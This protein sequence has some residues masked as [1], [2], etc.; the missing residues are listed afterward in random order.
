MKESRSYDDVQDV[1][2]EMQ[3]LLG[4]KLINNGLLTEVMW[5][6]GAKKTTLLTSRNK[7]W[8]KIEV[9]QDMV[10]E[11]I[12]MIISW[13][14]KSYSRLGKVIS[15]SSVTRRKDVFCTVKNRTGITIAKDHK[16]LRSHKFLF[17]EAVSAISYAAK[18]PKWKVRS[19]L[20][21]T[22]TKNGHMTLR[23]SNKF[24]ITV[25]IESN[26]FLF[27]PGNTHIPEK[28]NVLV[29]CTKNNNHKIYRRLRKALK[30]NAVKR[31][32][33][34]K[35]LEKKQDIYFSFAA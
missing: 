33:R 18:I 32:Y 1:F 22:V 14:K 16:Q 31:R 25:C 21:S 34:A 12:I 15:L 10:T 9:F 7:T 26:D 4:R 23:V 8:S 30:A 28:M 20:R 5:R 2:A 24:S 19:A 13:K 27:I 29:S 35:K 3:K 11:K 17:F 6:V